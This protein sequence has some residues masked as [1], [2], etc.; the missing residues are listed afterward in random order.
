MATDSSHRPNFDNQRRWVGGWIFEPRIIDGRLIT[1]I[2][3]KFG[4][5]LLPLYLSD[6]S[7][8]KWEIFSEH[9]KSAFSSA[10]RCCYTWLSVEQFQ[11]WNSRDYFR[12]LHVLNV[13]W[14]LKHLLSMI[15]L[16][17][18]IFPGWKVSKLT[19]IHKKGDKCSVANYGGITSLS[20]RSKVFED[21]CEQYTF[22]IFQK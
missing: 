16:Q 8:S 19:P 17:L 13:I 9:F 10:D 14:K 11:F 18:G 20:A 7:A 22:R 2:A 4:D 3:E 5:A 15:S 21:S 1:T 12:R 6:N